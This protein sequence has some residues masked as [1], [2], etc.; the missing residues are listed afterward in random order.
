M[1]RLTL[2]LTMA[3]I[4]FAACAQQGIQFVE[5]TWNEILTKA[6]TADKLIFIDV[7]T[8][9][10]GPCKL[11]AAE[12]FP[13]E[14]VGNLF[15]TSFV[16]YKIDAEKG[17]GID[18]AKQYGVRSYPTYLFIDGDGKLVYRTSGYMPAVP[19]LKEANIALQEKNDP[20]P[21]VVWQEEYEKGNRDTEFLIGYMKKRALS[22]L[23]SPEIIEELVPKLSP[24]Q[25]MDKEILGAIY[26]ADPTV[27]IV[28]GG[29]GFNYL[30]DNR[31]KLDSLDLVKYALGILETGINNYFQ[32]NIIV[33]EREDQLPVMITSYRK[34]LKASDVN[35]AEQTATAKGV[36]MKYYNGTNQVEKLAT[37]AIDY[38]DNGLMKTDVP[39]KIESDKKAFEEFMKPYVEG[40]ADSLTD[41]NYTMMKRLM[42]NQEMGNLSY[43]LRDAAEYIYHQSEDPKML[44]RATEWAR[45]A[46]SYFPHFSSAAVYA[47][48]L[49]KNGNQTE[50]VKQMEIACQD[51][52]LAGAEEVKNRLEA[53]LSSIR[54]GEAPRSLWK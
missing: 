1:K 4:A 2:T 49:L 45:Q 44:K 11:M 9:W 30:Y 51:S 29:H 18:I 47:G 19:F 38:V 3:V 52:F 42:R 7:Y 32:K 24:T 48:L 41:P 6:K 54:K 21:L 33:Q 36:V 23:A 37:A 25:L 16:N 35:D 22:K 46:N 12:T 15:N 53:S 43:S 26:F 13:L 14:S 40:K 27:Q 31:E 20:K 8:S 34:L 28:P 10:C 5:G 50:A 17:E 39:K